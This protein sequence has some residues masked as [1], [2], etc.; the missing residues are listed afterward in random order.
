MYNKC[1][2]PS[3]GAAQAIKPI[4]A[5]RFGGINKSIGARLGKQLCLFGHANCFGP[6][7]ILI[8]Q[9]LGSR[10]VASQHAWVEQRMLSC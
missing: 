2:A 10:G 8:T 6:L 1:F 5:Y 9:V 4:R 7:T 3:S